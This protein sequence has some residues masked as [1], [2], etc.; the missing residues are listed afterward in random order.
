MKRLLFSSLMICGLLASGADR[1]DRSVPAVTP[2]WSMEP[3]IWE[4][5]INTS[6]AAW[7]LLN[8]YRQH[9][10]PVGAILLDSPWSTAYNNFIFDEAR[11]PD[12]RGMIAAW[13]KQ[14]V[15]TVL[16]MTHIIN[17]KK[18]K[19]DAVGSDEDLFAIGQERGYFVNNGKPLKW[20]KGTGG[21]IDFTNPEAVAWWH[22]LMDRSL[23]L[24]IDGWKVDGA[25]E[26]F[27]LTE[28]KTSKGVLDYQDYLD[29]YYRDI[30][31]YGR[32]WKP[33]F[34]TMVRSVDIANSMGMDG[35]HAPLDAAPL[36]WTGDQRHSWGN[37]GID[38]AA[39]SFFRALD[40]GYPVVSSDT[41]GYQSASGVKGMPRLLFLRWA[42]WNALTPFFINGGHDEHRPWMFDA[43]FLRVFRRYMWLHHEMVPYFYSRSVEANLR[44]GLLMSHGPGANEFLLGDE[45][46]VGVMLNEKPEREMVF[47]AGEWL[48][49]WDPSKVY[50]GGDKTTVA[51]PEDRSP[52][53]VKRGSI[54]PMNV[55]NNAAGHGDAK[56][57][58]WRTLDVYPSSAPTRAVI[59]DPDQ[60]PPRPD[61][62]RTVVECIPTAKGVTLKLAGGPA[63][64][65]IFRVLLD[66]RYRVVRVRQA[67]NTS[68]D[69]AR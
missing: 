11:Y 7:D 32:Q 26:M 60:F 50:H 64:D 48:D 8:G 46:L 47:P 61:R 66:G 25:A 45:L 37:K 35:P 58:G 16:W 20:W 17:T 63:R 42:Q 38:E 18:D 43:E 31:H 12:P 23:S 27:Y 10:L 59:W 57:K 41:G 4:D 65:T 3:W 21:M 29:L 22:R 5:D 68:V 53:F 67:R 36:T 56:S 39:R 15:R 30:Y 55:E 44:E 13:R 24:G 51:V 19:A 34:V 14:G 6:K 40:L 69:V 1:A 9:D 49:Y 33:D 28:K 2:P 52:V 62:D 54:I